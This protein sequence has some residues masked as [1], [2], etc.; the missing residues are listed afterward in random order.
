MPK[1]TPDLKQQIQN[2][3]KAD[4]E[5]VVIKIAGK[6]K[7]VFDYLQV[8]FFN[9]EFGEQDLF[10]EAKTDLNK[11]FGKSY[12]GF[13]EQLQLANMLSACVKRLNEFTKINKNKKLEADLVMYI[14]DVPFSCSGNF[15]GT[16][17]TAFDYR[18]GLLVKRMVTLVNSKLHEDYRIEYTEKINNYLKI[19]HRTSSH[20]DMIYSLPQEI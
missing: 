1:I 2:L 11:L 3:S 7:A 13:S 5:K 8:N 19:L 10:E 16:C 17:F 4:L 20:I 9:K 14:L 18:V 12:K 15:Y 6:N